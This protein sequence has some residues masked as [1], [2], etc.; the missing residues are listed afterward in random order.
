MS[1]VHICI[2]KLI[3]LSLT[4]NKNT[5]KD[6]LILDEILSKNHDI[7]RSVILSLSAKKP[8]LSLLSLITKFLKIFFYIEKMIHLLFLII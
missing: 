4:G 3:D 1:C 2:K 6:L 8:F 7:M 5:E